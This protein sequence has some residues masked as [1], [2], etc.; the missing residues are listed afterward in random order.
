MENDR[1]EVVDGEQP[2]AADGCVLRADRVQRPPREVAGEDDVVVMP[3]G[4]RAVRR[5]RV[6]DRN[7]ALDGDVLVDSDLLGELALERV[8]Q[9]LA[10]V[11]AA[12]GKQPVLLARLLVPAEQ[13]RPAPVEHGRHA[14]ARFGRHAR[15]DPKPRSP[16]S[17][18]GNSSTMS[19][20]T[21]GSWRMTSCAMRIPGSTSNAS[22][23]SVLSSTTR[24]SPRYPESI[25]PGEFTFPIPC[26]AASPE[27]GS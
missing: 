13:D 19:S 12:A 14:D 1:V 18:S 21:A 20:S 3:A 17:L 25:S 8:D 5:N 26:R 16:R 9:A 7:R 22:S 10:R 11:H 27:R 24:T 23:R 4:R 15:D 2:V 6:D